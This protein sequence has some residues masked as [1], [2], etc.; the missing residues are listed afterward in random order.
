MVSTLD[1]ESTDPSSNL[2]RTSSYVQIATVR[3]TLRHLHEVYRRRQK[4]AAG[5]DR[6]EQCFPTRLSSFF[7]TSSYPLVLLTY[8]NVSAR[9]RTGDLV[10]VRRT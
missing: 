9:A 10:R 1:F 6:P 4:L 2:G 5:Y 8:I 3:S 7:R